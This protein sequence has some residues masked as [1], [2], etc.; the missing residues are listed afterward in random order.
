MEEEAPNK[1]NEIHILIDDVLALILHRLTARTLC[2]YKY[3]CC[4]WNR[5]ISGSKYRKEL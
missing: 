4:S 5:L 2:S 3:V 1:S